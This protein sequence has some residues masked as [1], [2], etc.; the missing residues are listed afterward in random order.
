LNSIPSTEEKKKKE[1]RIS[2]PLVP[3]VLRLNNHSI[4]I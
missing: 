4:F 1:K 2:M 3:K